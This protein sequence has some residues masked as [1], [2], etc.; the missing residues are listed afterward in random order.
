MYDKKQFRRFVTGVLFEYG[1]HSAEA[2][3]LLLGTAAQESHFGKYLR[4]NVKEFDINRHAM[5]TFQMEKATFN[6]LQLKYDK[7]FPVLQLRQ[8]FEMEYD[9]KLATLMCRL[10]YLVDPKPLP[11]TLKGQAQAWKRIYNTVHGSGTTEEYIKNYNRFV[12]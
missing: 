8:H 11:K 6:W 4:Q 10:R 3:D 12:V 2:V 5:G 1:L 7:R 9:L